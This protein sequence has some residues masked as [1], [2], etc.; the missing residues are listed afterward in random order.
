MV[1]ES[2][3]NKIKGTTHRQERK[4]MGWI[5]RKHHTESAFR[6]SSDPSASATDPTGSTTGGMQSTL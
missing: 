1:D 3:K 4:W 2:Y 6:D 5:T